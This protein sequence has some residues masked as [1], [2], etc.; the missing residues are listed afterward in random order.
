MTTDLTLNGYGLVYLSS[1]DFIEKI[2]NGYG[3]DL[4]NYRN[5]GGVKC[6][7]PDGTKTYFT[8]IGAGDMYKFCDFYTNP[9]GTFDAVI[10]DLEARELPADTINPS[11]RGFS[12][13]Q[14]E[15]PAPVVI[16]GAKL[17]RRNKTKRNSKKNVKSAKKR[18]TRRY[19]RK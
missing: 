5:R 13:P 18:T 16:G 14:R 2:V 4:V 10:A 7:N 11:K 19:Q 15:A 9:T 12:L 1:Y 8:L 17:K 3:C 6:P